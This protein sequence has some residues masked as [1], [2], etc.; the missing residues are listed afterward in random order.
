VKPD[1]CIAASTWLE[2]T[3]RPVQIAEI[4]KGDHVRT[5]GQNA[6][7]S[8]L[9]SSVFD[10][11]RKDTL[12]L[13][14]AGHSIVATP[15]HQFLT[16]RSRPM[17]RAVRLTD[18]GRKAIRT[19]AGKQPLREAAAHIGIHPQSLYR[20]ASEWKHTRG[21]YESKLLKV[22]EF[23]GVQLLPGVHYVGTMWRR[24]NG[25]I[26]TRHA[27]HHSLEW[28][29]SNALQ[30]GDSVVVYTPRRA[31]GMDLGVPL[32]DWRGFLRLMGCWLGDGSYKGDSGI[33]FSLPKGDKHR[34]TYETLARQVL[35]LEPHDVHCGFNVS[36]VKWTN[37]MRAMGFTGHAKTKRVPEWVFSL[38]QNEKW[39]LVLG[40]ADAD[41]HETPTAISFSTVSEG[42]C[43]D[44]VELTRSLG[45]PVSNIR[46]RTRS[47]AHLGYDSMTTSWEWVLALSGL[48]GTRYASARAQVASSLLPSDLSFRKLHSTKSGGPEHVF[49]LSI[50]SDHN[51]FANGLS[52]HNC[53]P[54]GWSSPEGRGELVLS[55][56][57]GSLDPNNQGWGLT[58]GTSQATARATG[59]LA[60]YM[61][62]H[63]DAGPEGIK[64]VFE[65]IARARGVIAKS[66]DT[67]WGVIDAAA[68]SGLIP[69]PPSELSQPVSG[70]YGAG[71]LATVAFVLPAF[72]EGLAKGW[73]SRTAEHAGKTIA[74]KKR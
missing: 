11:G 18:M 35:G 42:L 34:A 4:Q 68:M 16:L 24:L 9:V 46:N 17:D 31:S 61:Q 15:E 13:R 53:T 21:M 12:D 44:M 23:L 55:H 58:K 40:Y 29:E 70:L 43:Q 69:V 26:D 25:R 45:A 63:P 49:D 27:Y 1:I 3:G 41:G 52:V 67:G 50:E 33:T 64:G 66:P 19:R 8:G 14:F 7:R 48:S 36:S 10:N 6:V 72:A 20:F 22:A 2:T 30:R 62:Q 56:I 39:A 60:T 71:I 37:I 32:T 5:F 28:V 47:N 57:A 38:G 59:V 51:Y 65:S 74:P 54:G 73:G